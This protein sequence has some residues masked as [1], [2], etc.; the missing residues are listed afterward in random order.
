MS[1]FTCCLF[2][3]YQAVF[4][5]FSWF[6][7]I[8]SNYLNDNN[9]LDIVPSDILVGL[10][11]ARRVGR[12]TRL[13]TRERLI[14]A[15]TELHGFIEEC[16][17]AN[18]SNDIEVE[19]R[20]EKPLHLKGTFPIN[21]VEENPRLESDMSSTAISTDD[22]KLTSTQKEEVISVRDKRG[23]FLMAE[24]AHF[25]PYAQGIY[26]W[27]SYILEH[28][29]RGFC[30]LLYHIIVRCA[31]LF[32]SS[33]DHIKGDYPWQPHTIAFE[34]IT[35]LDPDDIL[36]ASYY[37]HIDSLPYAICLDHDWKTVVVTIRGTL[38]LES[39]FADINFTPT[40]LAE[41]GKECGFEGKGL[42]GHRGMVDSAK[43][44]YED[45]KR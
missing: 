23:R 13:E 24:A 40:E 25:V 31:C 43:W 2:G 29:V 5:D 42:Y 10:H 19:I 18:D 33:K 15:R 30:S 20:K 6:S 32:R 45:M 38:T 12:C 17:E 11:M 26:T 35:G 8:M 39:V 34:L 14:L 28:P 3:G 41:M 27:V 21:E 1:I 9:I 7:L 44:V 22:Q 36:Y 37:D 4:S 16:Y